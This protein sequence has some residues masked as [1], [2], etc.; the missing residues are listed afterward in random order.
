MYS[1]EMLQEL[2]IEVLYGWA[3]ILLLVWSEEVKAS[4]P[5]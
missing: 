1:I 2:I 4:R 3:V 5:Q